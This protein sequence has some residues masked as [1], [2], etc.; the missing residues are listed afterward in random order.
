MVNWYSLFSHTGNETRALVKQLSDELLLKRALTTNMAY[1]G[2]LSTVLRFRK[3]AWINQWLLQPGNV[4]PNSIVTLNGYM[5]ILPGPVLG[6]LRNIGCTVL[7]IHPAP[8]Q[9]YPELRGKDPQERLYDGVQDGRYGYV[10]VVIHE[11]DDGVDTG[12]IINWRLELADPSMSKSE[13]Y[14][15]LHAMSTEL[16]VET[17]KEY[18]NGKSY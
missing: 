7:N 12:K 6:Y 13:L 14:E 8:I 1:T 16:W 5:R 18:T 11:V 2:P 9:L 15:H 17:L 10:G 3:A 4:C